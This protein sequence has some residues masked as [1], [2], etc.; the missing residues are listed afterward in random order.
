M[1]ML[2]VVG[3]VHAQVGADDLVRR[4]ARP[5]LEIIAEAEYSVQIGDMGDDQ[6]YDVL[7][8]HVDPRRHRFFGGNHEHYDGLPPHAMGDF[9]AV[10]LGG[11]EFFFV[12]GAA[13]IDKVELL[14][15]GR[16]VG[17]K[18][19]HEQE[20]LTDDEM[21]SAE[22]AYLV[23]RPAIMLTHDSPTEIARQACAH[24]AKFAPP[25]PE[26]AYRPS[27]TSE[28][29]G[30]LWEQHQPRLWAFGHYHRDWRDRVGATTFACVGE[31]SFIDVAPNGEICRS[32]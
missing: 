26:A 4:N 28:F 1:T 16:Q 19:W 23:A 8:E 6:A 13:S 21:Q 12:R 15:M 3:D 32:Q 14:R 24:A 20:E 22:R 10:E 31:L 2:R 9:G 27:R 25:N 30:R 29:L 17:K 11:V 7:R 18:L 5:Y